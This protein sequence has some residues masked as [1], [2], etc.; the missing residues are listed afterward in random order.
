MYHHTNES[1]YET[2]KNYQEINELDTFNDAINRMHNDWDYLDSEER[3]ALALYLKNL[4]Q[5]SLN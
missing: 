2:I 5:R 1:A 3:S 4:K